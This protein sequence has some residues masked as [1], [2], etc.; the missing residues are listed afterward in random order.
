MTVTEGQRS[1][2]GGIERASGDKSYPA[3]RCT[4]FHS[5]RTIYPSGVLAVA[6]VLVQNLRRRIIG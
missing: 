1:I 6:G 3:Q 4:T 5:S 2:A